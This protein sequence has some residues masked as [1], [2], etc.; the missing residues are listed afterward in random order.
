MKRKF[1][2]LML[3]LAASCSITTFASEERKTV[4]ITQ[5]GSNHNRPKRSPVALPEVYIDDYTLTFDESCIGCPLTLID[6]DDNIVY[7]T[8]IDETGIVELPN[9]LSGIFEIE[10]ERGSIT[11]VG[12]IEL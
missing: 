2:M 7:T 1:I 12:E 10:I 6:E 4:K 3:M 5:H 9:T 8:I 11:F